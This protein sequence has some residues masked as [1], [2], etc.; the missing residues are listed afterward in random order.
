MKK[1]IILLL[2]LV[3]TLT[4]CGIGSN[5]STLADGKNTIALEDAFKNA[6]KQFQ[7]HP[8]TQRDIGDLQSETQEILL[9]NGKYYQSYVS[10]ASDLRYIFISKSEHPMSAEWDWV[11]IGTSNTYSL[12]LL[13]K[14]DEGY[15]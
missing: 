15:K 1:I 10:G 13:G 9:L 14:I 7:Q 11:P 5:T 12:D 6:T 4:A 8:E 3:C 2:C